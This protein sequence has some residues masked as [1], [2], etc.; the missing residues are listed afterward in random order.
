MTESAGGLF[1]D[2]VQGLLRSSIL[3][4][5]LG[6]GHRGLVEPGADGRPRRGGRR[7]SADHLQRVRLQG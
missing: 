6:Q 4:A 5:A 2:R 3:D 1:H 7:Q